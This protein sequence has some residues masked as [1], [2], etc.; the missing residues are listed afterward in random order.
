MHL[1]VSANSNIEQLISHVHRY[2]FDLFTDE[3]EATELL[4]MVSE[5]IYNVVKYGESGTIDLIVKE[6]V[7]EVTCAD[8]GQGFV[9]NYDEV[10]SEG[11]TT[12]GSLGLGMSCLLRLSDELFIDT[13]PTG[14]II[15]LTKG[16]A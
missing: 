16:L 13:A 15:R 5:M 6:D 3:S 2:A 7:V 10:F 4:T 9:E 1:K 8:S 12:G 11:Y 14:T